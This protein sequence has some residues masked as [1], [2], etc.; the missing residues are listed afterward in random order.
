MGAGFAAAA[1]GFA[2]RQLTAAGGEV[3]TEATITDVPLESN[4]VNT[5]AKGVKLLRIA[6]APSSWVRNRQVAVGNFFIHDFLSVECEDIGDI[7][8]CSSLEFSGVKAMRFNSYTQGT[9]PTE[10][11]TDMNHEGFKSIV[12]DARSLKASC[13]YGPV[14]LI[15]RD[16][17]EKCELFCGTPTLRRFADNI[18]HDSIYDFQLVSYRRNRGG[19]NWYEPRIVR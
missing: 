19:R 13:M 1:S 6:Q 7:I 2:G 10:V 3:V 8:G 4:L 9:C 5:L 11:F 16:N 15:T 12:K 17:G 18:R 14:Y